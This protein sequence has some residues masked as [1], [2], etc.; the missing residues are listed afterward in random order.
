MPACQNIFYASGDGAW[1]K[2][3]IKMTTKKKLV[4]KKLNLALQGGG[5]Y[6]AYTWGVL[7]YLLEQKQFDIES[8]TA[9]SAG[10][11]N[12]AVMMYGLR[13]ILI[14]WANNRQSILCVII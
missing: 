2:A 3:T 7:D 11:M 14:K 4:H 5:A 1:S 12:V 9:T 6:G 8:I 13:R 10:S